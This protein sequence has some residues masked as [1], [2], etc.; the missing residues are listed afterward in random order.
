MGKQVAEHLMEQQILRS[1]EGNASPWVRAVRDG[2]IESRRLVTDAAV[3]AVIHALPIRKVLDVGCGEGWL[4][5]RLAAEGLEVMGVDA[6][7]AL[8]ESASA[9]DTSRFRVLRYEQL[10][11]DTLGER[12]DLLVCNFSL[13]GKHSVECVVNASTALLNA[14]GYLLIQTL[15]PVASCGDLPYA[16]GW[17]EG[18]WQGCGSDFSDPAPWYFRTLE[19]WL[20]LIEG[21][22]LRVVQQL[23]PKHPLSQAPVSLLLLAQKPD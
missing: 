5:R 14:G 16:D 20:A 22:G 11:Y 1:W 17:R 19:S 15:N 6:I 23:E 13:L 21:S 4:S 9:G 7:P 12:F 3:L 2:S 8:V 10:C 18:S